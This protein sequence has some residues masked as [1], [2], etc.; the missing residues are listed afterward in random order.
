M[1][2]QN[3]QKFHKVEFLGCCKYSG[4][5]KYIYSLG[6][7]NGSWITQLYQLF[8]TESQEIKFSITTATN[9]LP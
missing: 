9:L 1:P 6:L 7:L 2:M 4:A 3:R 5:N 8:E